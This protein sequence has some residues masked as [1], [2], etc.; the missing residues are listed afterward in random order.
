MIDWAKCIFC[1][2]VSRKKDYKLINIVTFEACNSIRASAEARGDEELLPV[3]RTVDLI[4]SEGKYHKHHTWQGKYQIAVY[5]WET[6]QRIRGCVCR[7][8]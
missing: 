5:E 2:N 1:R 8:P 6:C 3:S 4:A 7:V